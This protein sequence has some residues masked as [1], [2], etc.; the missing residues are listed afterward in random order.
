[1]NPLASLILK[2]VFLAGS[3]TKTEIIKT[4]TELKRN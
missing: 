4:V 2:E 1:M 3:L